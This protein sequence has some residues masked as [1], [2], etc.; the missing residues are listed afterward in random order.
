MLHFVSLARLVRTGVSRLS[1]LVL[2]LTLG[3]SGAASATPW[4][5]GDVIT[6]SQTD[7]GGTPS[8][9]NAAALLVAS[10]NAVYPGGLEV[11]LSGSAGFS[12]LFTASPSVLAYLPAG[13]APG[14][15]NADLVDP[16]SSSSGVFGG[17]VVALKLNID[18]SDANI[19]VGA[20][21]THFGDLVLYGFTTT[22][23]LNGMTVRSY[24]GVVNTALGG[25]SAA[26]PIDPT[27]TNLT[28]EIDLAFEG[29]TPSVFV[30]DHLV[31]PTA[32]VPEPG[33]LLLLGSGL[34]G[35]VAFRVRV[36]RR[37]E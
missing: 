28:S 23:G 15:L 34:V 2:M 8:G 35:M 18:F 11:G 20:A 27:L 26:Y 6:W 30:Q 29:G 1:F 24:L 32:S 7:W 31:G 25:G 5:V 19:L 13:G 21:G 16:G 4:Q 9:T 12:M 10:F 22:P 3:I 33:T 17:L 36:R 37:H 14:A